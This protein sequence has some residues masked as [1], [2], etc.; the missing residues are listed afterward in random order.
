MTSQTI[1]ES[2]AERAAK[3]TISRVIC[4]ETP[5]WSEDVDS[6]GVCT[7]CGHEHQPQNG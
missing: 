4:L 1:V 3:R 7:L 2:G 5:F 6:R